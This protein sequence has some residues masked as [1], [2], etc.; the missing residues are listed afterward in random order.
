MVPFEQSGM[1]KKGSDLMSEYYDNLIKRVIDLSE[2]NSWSGAVNEW[3]IIDMED[4]I[5]QTE[6]CV[7]GH[8]NLRYL[9]TIRNALNGNILYPIGSTC[10]E[11][12][13]RNDLNEEIA[14]RRKLFKLYNGIRNRERIEL[15]SE[16]FSRKTLDFLYD[17]EAFQPNKYNDYDGSND[18]QFLL[19]MFNQRRLPTPSQKRKINAIIAFSIKPYLEKTIKIK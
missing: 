7:C 6:S 9:F 18:Y 17:Q 5:T 4:D 10:I 2:S 1:E 3:E 12:F 8:E 15:N 11:K 14:V 13:Q 16:W 19:K